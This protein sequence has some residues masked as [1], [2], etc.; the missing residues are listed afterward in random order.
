M[1]AKRWAAICIAAIAMCG[2][3]DNSGDA[4]EKPEKP[5][6]EVVEPTPKLLDFESKSGCAIDADCAAGLFCFRGACAKECDAATACEVGTCDANG[7]C[8]KDNKAKTRALATMTAV[9]AD[10]VPTAEVLMAPKSLIYVPLRADTVEAEL[11]LANHV[12]TL[13]YRVDDGAGTAQVAKYA[14]PVEREE[15]VGSEKYKAYVYKFV[16]PTTKS[17][18]GSKGDIDALTIVSSAGS[19]SV[20]LAPM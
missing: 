11:V 2:C 5:G 10:V 3:S 12:G 4:D 19:W 7:R 13:M 15:E 8:I 20:Q 14:E 1:D 9:V 16:L 17:S 6:G 18:L